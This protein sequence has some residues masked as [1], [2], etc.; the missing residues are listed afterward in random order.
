MSTMIKVLLL[1]TLISGL[2]GQASD[3][4]KEQSTYRHAWET[5]MLD[6]KIT[7]EER[8]LMNILVE[9]M[10]LSLDSSRTWEARWS[11]TTP[12]PMDQSGRWPLVLQ[13]IALGAGLYGWGI[14]YVLHADDGRWYVG[15]VMVSMGG[16]FYLTYGYTK[17]MDMSHA[18][19]QMMR[20]GSLLGLR[21]GAGLN[22]LLGLDDGSDDED[23]AQSDDPETLWMWVLMASAPVGHYAGEYLFEKYEPSNGQA[24]VWSMWTGVAGI[25]SRLI[26]N[27]VDSEPDSADYAGYD[28]LAEEESY[29]SDMDKWRKRKTRLELLAYPLGAMAGYRLTHHKQY[30]FG[31]AFMLMQ[32]W[33]FG[34]YNTMMFQSILFDDGDI[35]MFFLVSS[36]GAIGSTLA[37]DHFIKAHDYSFGQ[38]TLM[39]LGSASGTAFGFGTGILLDV[40]DTEPLLILALIGYGGGTYLTQQ[41][42]NLSP[43][44]ALAHTSSNRVSLSPTVL[45]GVGSDQ[46]VNL[47]P[48]LMLNISFK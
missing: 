3:S 48:G 13:N 41:I 44:G 37:Y 26:H 2:A 20:Y 25:T 19:T 1:V 4:L 29:D 31:D 30:S 32:G 18:R 35:D 45:T 6:G 14:P 38:S 40:Q 15:G 24:W 34:F 43:D 17:T 5:A 36:L 46:K 27:V 28:W 47:I 12:K 9:S 16:A 11:F 21:Y 23:S 33:G 39:L 42:L 10:M 22:Q 7:D 8:V